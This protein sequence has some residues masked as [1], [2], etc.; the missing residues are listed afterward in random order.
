MAFLINTANYY[1]Y[2]NFHEYKLRECFFTHINL[3]TVIILG[4]KKLIFHSLKLIVL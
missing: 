3:C 4:R 2:V 1:I